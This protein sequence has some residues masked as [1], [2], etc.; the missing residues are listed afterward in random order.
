MEDAVMRYWIKRREKLIHPYSLVGYLL[1]P[2]KIIMAHAATNRSEIH[3]KAVVTLI[4][5][6]LIDPF[7]VGQA[8]SDAVANAIN[9]F[10]DEFHFFQSKRK[11][12]RYEHMWETKTRETTPAFRWHE[13]NSLRSTI[14]LG[15]L[16]CLVLSKILGVGT[17]ER[18]WK[19]VK[20]IKSG[21]RSNISSEKCKKQVTL[22]GQN[23][24]L[25]ATARRDKLS[26]VG[27][28]WED[29]DFKTLKMDVYCKDM[30]ESLDALHARGP[31]K[32]FRC[33]REGWEK[34]T[35]SL[36]PQGCVILHEKLRNKY[37]GFK[38]HYYEG[39]TPRVFLIHDIMF[40]EDSRPRKYMIIGVNSD[41]NTSLEV[42][43][44]DADTF[45]CWDF[46]E[47]T[48][49]CIRVYYNESSE[50]ENVKLYNKGGVCD[51]DVEDVDD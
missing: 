36:G 13:R 19:Q 44:N 18:N 47:D 11:M 9:T 49:D 14:I 40:K 21:Q 28:L 8:K 45:N 20:L 3:N 30:W 31:E 6:L 34:P 5:R 37:V 24:Q 23:Q 16:A 15:K 32:I 41:F 46:N 17:A 33:W 22:Y 4:K 48:Y 25:K 51:S 29:A 43:E 10:W 39:R 27:K 35:R 12:F 50:R 1:S 38:L 2:S 42:D 7:L 26:S